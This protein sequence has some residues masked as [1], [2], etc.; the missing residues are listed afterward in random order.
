MLAALDA[1]SLATP[2]RRCCC[3]AAAIL[4]LWM[5]ELSHRAALEKSKFPRKTIAPPKTRKEQAGPGA[6]MR[7]GRGVTP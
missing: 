5:G 7:E 1:L 3:L 4:I 2:K 6:K